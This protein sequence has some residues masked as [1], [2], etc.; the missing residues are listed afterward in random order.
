MKFSNVFLVICFAIL[1]Y[2]SSFGQDKFNTCSAIF[3]EDSRLVDEYSP[4]G[5]CI[6]DA[7]AKGTLTVR[8][9]IG[10]DDFR[11]DVFVPFKVAIK[12]G[13]TNT[14]TLF[15]GNSYKKLDIQSV[16]KKC[17]KGDRVLV[18]PEGEKWSLPHHEVL[19]E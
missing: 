14:L 7:S 4:R 19:V 2:F 13:K 8:E 9:I 11:Q 3:V 16:L 6:I 10:D 12:E 1:S 5:K 17:N 15:S 18:L